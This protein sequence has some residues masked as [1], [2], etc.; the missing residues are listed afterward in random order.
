MTVALK[1]AN[2]TDDWLQVLRADE[3][4]SQK[5]FDSINA[6]CDE[7]IRLTAVHF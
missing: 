1:E 5:E 2:E 7:I 6:D 4:I 3:Y